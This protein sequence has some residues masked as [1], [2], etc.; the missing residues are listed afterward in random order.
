V[1][2]PAKSSKSQ[3]PAK[4]PTPAPDQF[5]K[6]LRTTATRIGIP[7]LIVWVV[8]ILIGHP[9]V[10]IGAGVLTLVALGI[11]GWAYWYMN[12]SK[13]VA[14]ILQTADV[15]TASGRKEAMGK[16]EDKA[17]KGDAAALFAKS[18]LLMHE[19]PRQALEVL[20]EI[21]LDK[22]MAP[23]ADEA[24]GQRAMIH[25]MLGEVDRARPLVDAIEL[26]RHDQLKSR[27]ALAAVVAEAWARSGQSKRANETLD[28]FDP[29]N[30]EVEEIKPQLYRSR[31]FAAAAQSDVKRMKHALRRLR[32]INPQL[33]GGFV[34]KKVHPLLEKEARQMLMQSGAVP[35]KMVRRQK[36]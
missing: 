11:V 6:L 30:D 34:Q 16:L 4:L 17:G 10:L 9:Y 22:V 5:K 15:S 25:L 27:A 13:A 26:S 23:V 18:Q 24:R 14:G 33:L 3:P 7:V 29:E 28:L 2:K 20:E 32:A 31:A 8:A 21:N 35:K 1:T 19:D 36:M 12:K